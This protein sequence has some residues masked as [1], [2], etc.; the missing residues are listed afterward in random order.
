MKFGRNIELHHNNTKTFRNS[1][2][3]TPFSVFMATARE[4]AIVIQEI[5]PAENH[6][7]GSRHLS[8]IYTP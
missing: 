1:F 3:I 6:D 8:P 5:Q 4:E 7:E 2:N